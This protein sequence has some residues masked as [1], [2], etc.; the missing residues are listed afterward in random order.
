MRRMIKAKPRIAT[1]SRA[2]IH[3]GDSTHHQLQVI[4]P[5]SF[6]PINRIVRRPGKPI[7]LE[8]EEVLLDMIFSKKGQQREFQQQ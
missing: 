2:L 8:E 3:R 6:K 4:L 1:A 5:V 7:P